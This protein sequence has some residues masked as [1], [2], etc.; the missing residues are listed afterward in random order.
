MSTS[1]WVVVAGYGLAMIA[2]SLW[3]GRGQR[4]QADYYVGGRDLPWWAIGIST[5]A[6]QTSAVS[7][8]SIPAF[9]ALKPGGGLTWLQFELAL[10]LAMIG[11]AM[12]L[13]PFFRALRLISIYE[14]L[15][16]RFGPGVRT[17]I[18]GV[19]LLSRALGTGVGL[20]AS[21]IVL[22]VVLGQPIWLTILA[23]GLLTL[24]Y[25][26]IGGMRAV[27]WSDVVQGAILIAGIGLCVGYAIA[28]AG[29][30]GTA[31]GALSGD[32]LRAIDPSLGIDLTGG[33]DGGV[34]FWGFLVGGLFLY[35][36][37]YG[38][39]QSQAQRALATRSIADTRRALYLNGFARFPLTLGYVSLGLVLAAVFATD[40]GLRA[41]VPADE[42]DFLVPAFIVQEL[43]AGARGMLI[44]A[45]LAASMSS[46]DSALNALSA[47]TMRDFVERRHPHLGA[48]QVM[49]LSRV[50]TVAWGLVVIAF[51]FL[52]GGISDTVI[53]AINK[54]GSTFYG[55]ILA[56]FLIGVL[57][58]RAT[59]RGI[60]AGVGAG[61]AFNLTLWL[62][63]A[64]VHWMWWNLTGLV[65]AA[66]V[67]TLVSR[68]GPR[69]DPAR[70]GAYTLSGS[71]F[72]HREG[73]WQP[74]YRW[75]LLYFLVL[76]AL[77]AGLTLLAGS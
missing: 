55:P 18:S 21:A 54:V 67:C 8:L 66:L 14:Y 74:A 12:L 77:L 6:T 46:M 11:V 13:L 19:F 73:L 48:A 23:M 33:G 5:M 52:L 29:D 56:A 24:V 68:L 25:D 28:H 39:D 49:A 30:L 15:E 76:L 58:R 42:L 1:D 3:L 61:V 36:A 31:L 69:P 27:V 7:F 41:Q 22:T 10:P 75:L 63:L 51:A 16:L 35:M 72:L 47:A 71:G 65:V 44:A 53:E 45:L 20:Y 26:T 37:Y 32:R 2:L 34:P 43:P 62:L 60:I 59:S 4:T 38:T 17:L 40:A 64:G 50:T 70:A 57:S 9:V